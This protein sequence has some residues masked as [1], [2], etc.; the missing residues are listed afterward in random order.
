MRKEI[1]QRTETYF[2]S[3]N[4]PTCSYVRL[5][6]LTNPVF[7]RAG[8]EQD[9]HRYEELQRDIP[10]PRDNTSVIFC[11]L[12]HRTFPILNFSPRLASFIYGQ[13]DLRIKTRAILNSISAESQ[14]LT[15]CLPKFFQTS[16]VRQTVHIIAQYYC[17]ESTL[18]DRF[19]PR[20]LNI[21][22]QYFILLVGYN[23]PT[24]LSDYYCWCGHCC[25]ANE[26][27]S[28]WIKQQYK[29]RPES[30][31]ENLMTDLI[32]SRPNDCKIILIRIPYTFHYFAQ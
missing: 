28:R 8:F 20:R 27:N 5:S 13:F 11:I 4:L 26:K 17:L 24:C 15:F 3:K 10:T 2:F 12:R 1:S 7:V 9:R 29:R 30:T 23:A 18:P 19:L 6:A 16:R 14:Y 25:L 32:P 21:I 22:A 31:R